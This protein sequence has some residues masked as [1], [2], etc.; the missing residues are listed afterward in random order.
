MTKKAFTVWFTIISTLLNILFTAAIIA[1]LA[2]V[3][4]VVMNK[5][6]GVR[7]GHIY[8]VVWMMCFLAGMVLGMFLF[9]KISAAIIDKQNLAG[10]LDA[11]VI[12]KYLPNGKVNR[13]AQEAEEE[14]V[15]TVM[16]DSVKEEEDTWGKE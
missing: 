13:Y 7:E 6:I 16:P 15:K 10:K 14:K 5:M 12:G 11:R 4:T 1:V 2:V 8:I 3:A 9:G